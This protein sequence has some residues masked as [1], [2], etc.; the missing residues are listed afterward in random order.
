VRTVSS[1]FGFAF[2]PTSAPTS[3]NATPTR[4]IDEP[5]AKRRKT[6]LSNEIVAIES[7]ATAIADVPK[8]KKFAKARRKVD[9]EY[10]DPCQATAAADDSFIAGLGARRAAIAKSKAKKTPVTKRNATTQ[11]KAKE[12]IA[13]NSKPAI[14]RLETQA[15]TLTRPRRRAAATAASKVANGFEEEAIP[16][17]MKRRIPQASNK[18]GRSRGR[19]VMVEQKTGC[20]DEKRG[21]PDD[22]SEA[23]VKVAAKKRGTGRKLKA[24]NDTTVPEQIVNVAIDGARDELAA[25]VAVWRDDEAAVHKEMCSQ[26]PASRNAPKANKKQKP[27]AKRTRLKTEAAP[28][29]ELSAQSSSDMAT[30]CDCKDAMRTASSRSTKASRTQRQAFAETNMNITMR[31]ASPEKLPPDALKES[32]FQEPKP[33]ELASAPAPIRP[34]LPLTTKPE[35]KRRKLNIKRDAVAT[36]NQRSEPTANIQSQIGDLSGIKGSKQTSLDQAPWA[37]KTVASAAHR[38]RGA[39]TVTQR[40]RNFMHEAKDDAGVET[41]ASCEISTTPVVNDPNMRNILEGE[42]VDRCAPADARGEDVDWLFAPQ[43]ANFPKSTT[44]KSKSGSTMKSRKFKM[45]EMDLDDLLSNIA[46]FAQEKTQPGAVVVQ[47][48]SLFAGGERISRG[49]A[50]KRAKV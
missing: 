8:S 2:G 19:E 16:I 1:N 44:S 20:E 36:T 3:H 6:I 31:S 35:P 50:R 22:A 7:I 12:I 25:S 38:S 4:E 30:D 46:T 39:T 5:P 43:Q 27:P 28:S 26:K 15:A 47:G 9:L 40:R 13:T 29:T 11:S 21:L 42:K 37:A 32:T 41:V 34:L 10:G 33:K 45:P 24:R 48:M 18:Y 23:P 17:D 14:E 49:G